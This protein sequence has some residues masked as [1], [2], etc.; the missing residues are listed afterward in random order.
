[1][2]NKIFD[3]YNKRWINIYSKRGINILKN[4]IKNI[5]GGQNCKSYKNCDDCIEE[6]KCL[7]KHK[8]NK[9]TGKWENKCRR[10]SILRKANKRNWNK[11]CGHCEFDRNRLKECEK[12]GFIETRRG[13]LN[14]EKIKKTLKKKGCKI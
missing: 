4:Y 13:P 5:E 3:R 12:I 1:M 6:E 8:K 14:C 7:W 11:D 9:K 2:Y 10:R